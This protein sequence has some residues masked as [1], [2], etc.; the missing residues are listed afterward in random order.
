MTADYSK[1]LG[2]SRSKKPG[3]K[4]EV[5]SASATTRVEPEQELIVGLNTVK[6]ALEARPRDCIKL[7]I[8]KT[9]RHSPEVSALIQLATNIGLAPIK[10]DPNFI[11]QLGAAHH[12]GLALLAKPKREP[13]LQEFL[14]SLPSS[15]PV[16]ILALDHLEDPHNFGALIR[17]AVAFGAHGLVY[18]KDR[19][20]PLTTAA[21]AASAGA[22]EVLSLIKV[23]NLVRALD[24]IKKRDFW[25]VA[26]EAGLGQSSADF[27]F[28]E[29]MV[30]ILG[31]EG[32]GIS[33]A[34]AGAA[35]FSVHI[36]LESSQV[37]SLNVSNAGAILM[38]SYRLGLAGKG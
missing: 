2:P 1:P 23:V 17:S 26:A 8:A 4:N 3:G 16:L 30:L 19:S 7:F 33:R 5:K 12:Q 9:R 37:A 29:R 24:D 35:D 25:V 20:A 6:T 14:D 28:P 10:V 31:S 11:E 13:S 32:S 21:R 36:A 22:V 15:G 27:D 34:V 18:P 38:H